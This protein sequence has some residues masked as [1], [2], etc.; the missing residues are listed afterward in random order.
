MKELQ[1]LTDLITPREI[2]TSQS[3]SRKMRI[4]L[5][6][7]LA[8]LSSHAVYA[9]SGA[10]TDL[11]RREFIAK[12]FSVNPFGPVRWMNGGQ[13]Y[14]TLEPADKAEGARDIVRYE[15][16]TAQREVLVSASQLVPSGSDK[17]LAIEDYAWS[18]DM[19][20]LLI[21]TNSTRVWR[22]NTRGDYW[23]LDRKSGALRKLGDGGT[24]S[25][26][27]FAKFSP[28]GSKVAYVRFNRCLP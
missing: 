16:A 21:F 8:C 3:L 7:T 4:A 5:S 27:M 20:R 15:T 28:D 23:V 18:A 1:M 2:Q 25:S 6:F 9:Q 14:V 19:N 10:V 26:L 12:D 17:A 11:L 22:A 24:P 13:S